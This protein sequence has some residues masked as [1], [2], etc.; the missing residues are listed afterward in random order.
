[1]KLKYETHLKPYAQKL[2]KA[3]NLSEVL[4][5]RELKGN[6]LGYRFLRQVPIASFIMDFYCHALKL[7]I[8]IDGVATHDAKVDQDKERQ[9]I[10]ESSGID[11]VR[12]KDSDIR[13]NISG[14][15]QTIKTE[16]LRRAS[17]PPPFKKEE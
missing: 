16:I 11:V 9:K 7:A 1:M 8:E 4:L 3:G 10:I 5:W 13:Y 14:V 2:R 6:K 15:I 12:F 17:A